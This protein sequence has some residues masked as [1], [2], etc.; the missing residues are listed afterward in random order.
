MEERKID[1][2]QPMVIQ[3]QNVSDEKKEYVIFGFNHFNKKKNYGNDPDVRVTSVTGCTYD[4]Y[5]NNTSSKEFRIGKMRFA[6]TTK[7]NIQTELFHHKYN[8]FRGTYK[9]KE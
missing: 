4:D 5:I 7:K 2:S 1:Y 8:V 9:R 3:V 6:S